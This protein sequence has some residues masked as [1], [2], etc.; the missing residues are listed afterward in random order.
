VLSLTFNLPLKKI[1][2]CDLQLAKKQT[3]NIA[4]GIASESPIGWLNLWPHVRPW[5]VS[6][7]QPTLRCV[8]QAANLAQRILQ[9]WRQVNPTEQLLSAQT[10]ATHGNSQAWGQ[11]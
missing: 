1:T 8:P 5:R 2:S 7:P 4:L 6:S 3:G 11:A 9:T 10:E